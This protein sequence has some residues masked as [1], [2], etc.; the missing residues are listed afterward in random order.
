MHCSMY[1]CIGVAGAFHRDAFRRTDSFLDPHAFVRTNQ[2]AR[3]LFQMVYT[4]HVRYCG[5]ANS[6]SRRCLGIRFPRECLGHG[7][8]ASAVL[9]R[10]CRLDHPIPLPR[11]GCQGR[12]FLFERTQRNGQC[13]DS[14]RC[15]LFQKGKALCNHRQRPHGASRT[16]FEVAKGLCCRRR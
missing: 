9:Q 14:T 8:R 7:S 6:L 2:F 3:V 5:L 15:Q 1:L 10:H 11:K 16:R 13:N 4:T 12:M